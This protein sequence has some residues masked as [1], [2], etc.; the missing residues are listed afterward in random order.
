MSASECY[1]VA[2]AI[3]LWAHRNDGCSVDKINRP[4]RMRRAIGLTCYCLS[5]SKASPNNSWII[6]I[7]IIIVG[8]V[9]W[10]EHRACI[11]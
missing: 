7:V 11:I 8:E 4:S 9:V 10:F 6:I 2:R 1:V 3:A 5:T